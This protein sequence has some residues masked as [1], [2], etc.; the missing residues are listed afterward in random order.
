MYIYIE[1]WCMRDSQYTMGISECLTL[2]EEI[3]QNPLFTSPHEAPTWWTRTFSFLLRPKVVKKNDTGNHYSYFLKQ[4]RRKTLTNTK[5]LLKHN[6]CQLPENFLLPQDFFETWFF[7]FSKRI[8]T[9][10]ATVCVEFNSFMFLRK[11]IKTNIKC[12]SACVKR[13]GRT[14][15]CIQ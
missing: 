2:W 1:T 3:V 6:T 10:S 9:P 4:K 15:G 7:S 13:L 12:I 14:D 5:E 8:I 11:C